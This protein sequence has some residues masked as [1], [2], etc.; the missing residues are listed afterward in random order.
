MEG[1]IQTFFVVQTLLLALP[2]HTVLNEWTVSTV[3]GALPDEAMLRK[4]S[5]V[6]A[7]RQEAGLPHEQGS[8]HFRESRR[9][10]GTE[11]RLYAKPQPPWPIS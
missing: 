4:H 10:T 11:N 2:C 8:A 3:L 1:G 6:Q 5:S 7:W 9:F